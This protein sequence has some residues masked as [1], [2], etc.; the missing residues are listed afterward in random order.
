MTERRRH[1]R[2][3]VDLGAWLVWEHTSQSV[4]IRNIGTGGALIIAPD[5]EVPVRGRIQVDFSLGHGRIA[6]D[7]AVR[8]CPRPGW[9]GVDFLGLSAETIREIE[10]YVERH[11]ATERVKGH[12][13]G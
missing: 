2:A 5:L 6:V 11:H 8:H 4:V 13:P 12:A 10:H 7:A 3:T 9:L 1:P